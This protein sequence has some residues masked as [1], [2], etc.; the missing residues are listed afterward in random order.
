MDPIDRI[1]SVLAWHC[2]GTLAVY[3]EIDSVLTTSGDTRMAFRRL[4]NKGLMKYVDPEQLE[5][6]SY[7]IGRFRRCIESMEEIKQL[8]RKI[9]A[10]N[11]FESDSFFVFNQE[12]SFS[13]A[14]KMMSLVGPLLPHFSNHPTR[15]QVINAELALA[16]NTPFIE[17]SGPGSE[18]M[19]LETMT[20]SSC[21][22]ARE[23]DLVCSETMD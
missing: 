23:V 3:M 22:K 1:A 10:V 19:C 4:V 2:L 7:E 18:L 5:A 16:M 8:A 9:F 21:P 17:I 6:I 20:S 12:I 15:T 14:C 11:F 13:Y